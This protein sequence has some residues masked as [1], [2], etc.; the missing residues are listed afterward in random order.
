MRNRIK[1]QIPILNISLKNGAS[2]NQLCEVPELVKITTE[3]TLE[4]INDAIKKNKKT[5]T[6]FEIANSEY[7]ITLEK[8][9]W[10]PSLEKALEYFTE[11]ENYDACINAR[12][13]LNKL[14]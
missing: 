9:Q 2:Y 5:T 10:V 1:R 6:L 4:A 12:D 7:T 11:N 14:K 3:T 8:K 13:L